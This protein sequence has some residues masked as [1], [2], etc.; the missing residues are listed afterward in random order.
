MNDHD[1][2][3]RQLHRKGHALERAAA[4]AIEDLTAVNRRLTSS[5][6]DARKELQRL[7]HLQVAALRP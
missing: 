4:E 5:L 3:L 2:L 6:D 1:E 7:R